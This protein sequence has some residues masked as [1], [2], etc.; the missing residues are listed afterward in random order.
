MI[1][2][3]MFPPHPPKKKSSYQYLA[4]KQKPAYSDAA[5]YE[6]LICYGFVSVI[7]LKVYIVKTDKNC[8]LFSI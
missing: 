2:M 3:Q 7:K 1:F 5:N 8:F 4:M 6:Q